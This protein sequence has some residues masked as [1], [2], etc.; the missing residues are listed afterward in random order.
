[1]HFATK[2]FKLAWTSI[3]EVGTVSWCALSKHKILDKV[4][5][6]LRSRTV[7][8]L[9]GVTWIFLIVEMVLFLGA[10]SHPCTSWI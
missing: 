6:I 7:L 4:T 3:V 8:G 2:I 5:N 9:L 1:V 10:Y